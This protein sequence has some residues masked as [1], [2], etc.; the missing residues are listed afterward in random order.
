[1]RVLIQRVKEASVAIDNSIHSK[2][3]KGLLIFLGV[4]VGDDENAAKYL[5]KRSADLRIFEDNQGKMNLSVKEISGEVLVVS[6][7]TLYADTRRGNRPS[8]TDAAASEFAEE[9][10][11]KFVYYL[12]NELSPDK[13]KTGVFGAMMDI[14]LINDGPVTIIIDSK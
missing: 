8:F 2:I 3:E 5:A 6:Q 14:K 10:Y 1:M 12:I 7:F 9:L 13:V 4:K 11:N